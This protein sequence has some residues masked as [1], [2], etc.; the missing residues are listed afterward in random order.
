MHAPPVFSGIAAASG[1]NAI[2]A[3]NIPAL[4]TILMLNRSKIAINVNSF[5]SRS[6]ISAID[7]A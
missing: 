4:A 6:D 5:Y 7:T 2:A 1:L 3:P